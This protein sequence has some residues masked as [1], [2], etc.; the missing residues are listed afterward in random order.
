MVVVK[1]APKSPL[2]GMFYMSFFIVVLTAIIPVANH[3]TTASPSSEFCI[4]WHLATLGTKKCNYPVS[5][6]V[7]CDETIIVSHGCEVHGLEPGLIGSMSE[8]AIVSI[9]KA[10]GGNFSDVSRPTLNKGV[11]NKPVKYDVDCDLSTGDSIPTCLKRGQEKNI[12]GQEIFELYQEVYLCSDADQ[13]KPL[14]MNII[15]VEESA[16][17][18]VEKVGDGDAEI[19]FQSEYWKGRNLVQEFVMRTNRSGGQTPSLVN[20]TYCR[21]LF[22]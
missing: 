19:G 20:K 5:G 4:N 11:L 21:G 10:C 14:P 18:A 16:K 7:V 6:I 9:K 17:K 3:S 13:H 1:M 8:V 12:T 22:I 2:M 15:R